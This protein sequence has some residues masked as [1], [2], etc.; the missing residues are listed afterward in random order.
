MNLF[1]IKMNEEKYTPHRF[2]TSHLSP[3]KKAWTIRTEKMREC[4]LEGEEGTLRAKQTASSGFALKVGSNL[5][6]YRSS[7]VFV[8]W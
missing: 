7:V 2:A 5:F 8:H 4:R 1:H 6:L 3:S